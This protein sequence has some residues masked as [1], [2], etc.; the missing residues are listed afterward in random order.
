MVIA[1][2]LIFTAYGFWLPNDPRGSWSDFVR[3]WE[4]YCRGHATK[5]TARRSQAATVHDRELRRKQKSALQY[6]PV[7]FSPRQIACV[8][9]GFARA[10]DESHYTVLACSIMP[11]HVHGV[12]AR[13]AN[14][15]ERIIGH[16]KARATQQLVAERLHP[17]L[18]PCSPSGTLPPAW[19]SRVWKVFLDRDADIQR[20]VDYVQDNSLKQ[21][22]PRQS[23]HFVMENR[24]H[25]G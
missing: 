4:L 16:L 14:P 2:H 9:R 21:R 12:V 17:F 23:W 10:V 6:D 11:D 3:S 22:L 7:Q 15:A 24:A 25:V 5:V 20:A 18:D 8:A 13:H 1:H 19:A